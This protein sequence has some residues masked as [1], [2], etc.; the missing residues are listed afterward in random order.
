MLLEKIGE[1]FGE[2]IKLK[3]RLHL[4]NEDE[5]QESRAEAIHEQIQRLQDMI[6]KL[7]EQAKSAD[8][9]V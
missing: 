8:D 5:Q 2:D 4:S 1:D 9:D 7:V 3:L 6:D